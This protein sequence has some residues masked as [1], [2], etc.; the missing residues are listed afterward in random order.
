MH[1]APAKQLLL[2]TAQSCDTRIVRDEVDAGQWIAIGNIGRKH[3]ITWDCT[4]DS[5]K[6]VFC[7][8][9]LAVIAKSTVIIQGLVVIVSLARNLHRRT[10]P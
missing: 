2:L 3:V 8:Q 10:F 1:S 5:I 4:V 9:K 6:E 7:S